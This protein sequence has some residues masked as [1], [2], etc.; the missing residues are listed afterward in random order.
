MI[1]MQYWQKYCQ[2]NQVNFI[3][4][5]DKYPLDICQNSFLPAIYKNL[6]TISAIRIAI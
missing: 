2:I 1:K 3:R 6:S 4:S 5:V